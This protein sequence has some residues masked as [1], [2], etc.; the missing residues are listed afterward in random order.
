[1]NEWDDETPITPREAC[2][3]LFLGHIKP[4]TLVAEA[5]RGNLQ[6]ER[7]GR[8]YF[9][10]PGAIKEMRRR[11]RVK[12]NALKV[13]RSS[14]SDPFGDDRAKFAKA[15]LKKTLEELKK[16]SKKEI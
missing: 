11:C 6:L 12:E 5:E 14:V 10:T 3:V 7:I 9:T 2:E 4:P 8:R 1:M 13:T 15:A 16:R